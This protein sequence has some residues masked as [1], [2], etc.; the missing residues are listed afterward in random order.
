VTRG[1]TMWQIHRVSTSARS[2]IY[3]E[4]WVRSLAAAQEQVD[5]GQSAFGEVVDSLVADLL[6]SREF[7]SFLLAGTSARMADGN[8]LDEAVYAVTEEFAA[9]I[10]GN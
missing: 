3:P 2:V 8:A 5:G 6:T 10:Q 7:L 4:W 9:R 1:T